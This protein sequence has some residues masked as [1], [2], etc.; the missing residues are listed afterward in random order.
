MRELVNS[1]ANK[2]Q[3]PGSDTEEIVL[4][5]FVVRVTL[6]CAR[7]YFEYPGGRPFDVLNEPH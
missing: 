2:S 1:A 3:A 4:E 5:W 6:A 7:G